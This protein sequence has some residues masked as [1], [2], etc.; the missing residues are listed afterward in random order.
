[1]IVQSAFPAGS[2]S[3]ERT[4]SIRSGSIARTR[5]STVPEKFAFG[6]GTDVIV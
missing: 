1:V 2:A 3:A 5:T 6:L 4:R